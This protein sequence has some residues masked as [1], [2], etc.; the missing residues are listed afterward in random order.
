M[1]RTKNSGLPQT[2]NSGLPVGGQ[3]IPRKKKTGLKKVKKNPKHVKQAIAESG[4]DKA[5][6][7]EN[8][9]SEDVSD[10]DEAMARFDN[11]DSRANPFGFD[12]FER[13]V[14]DD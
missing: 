10:D 5:V 13:S 14:W 8:E 3:K 4:A 2:K 1:L 9:N 6:E 11:P 12:A 7:S